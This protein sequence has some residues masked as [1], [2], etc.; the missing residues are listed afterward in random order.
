MAVFFIGFIAALWVFIAVGLFC[1][2]HGVLADR[3]RKRSIKRCVVD[4]LAFSMWP[5][6]FFYFA[7][8]FLF[9]ELLK[10]HLDRLRRKFSV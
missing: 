2:E 3:Y 10:K 8:A 9:E 4:A 5:L 6:F 7:A 1:L